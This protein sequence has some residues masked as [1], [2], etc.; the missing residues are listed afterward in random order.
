MIRKQ[1]SPILFLFVLANSILLFAN[2]YDGDIKKI[3]F[4][5][6]M[7]VNLM[8]FSMSIF[9]Y[10]RLRKIEANKPSAMV[11]SVMVGTLLKMVIFAGAALA[12]ATQKKGPV[13]Y[14]TLLTSMGLYLVYTWMEM[15][16]T[17]VN[18]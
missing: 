8:L 18:K 3:N 7:V 2:S 4:K 13:G 14:P 11:R 9:N 12:Y 15:S 1:L 5:F 10:F 6:V 17:K 16:W